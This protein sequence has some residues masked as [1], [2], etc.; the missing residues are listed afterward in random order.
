MISNLLR[1]RSAQL[2]IVATAA[3][4]AL[5]LGTGPAF[6]DNA[7][8]PSCGVTQPGPCSETDHFTNESGLQTPLGGTTSGTNCP[9]WVIDDFVLLAMSGNGVQHITV[10]KAQDS[11]F[12]STFTGDGTATFYPPSSIGNLVTDENGN[13][14]SYDIVG[15]ADNTLSGHLTNWFGGEDNNKNVVFLGTIDFSGTDQS[16]NALSIHDTQHLSWTGNQL[17]FVDAPH[18]AT[19]NAHC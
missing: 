15:P 12:T 11:W 6:A 13:I 7:P 8:Q 3:A 2:A 1:R 19:N 5:V 14:V 18:L 17:P 10:N 9:S 16:G 4:G